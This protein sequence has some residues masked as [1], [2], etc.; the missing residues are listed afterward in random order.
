M[1]LNRGVL[2]VIK[3]PNERSKKKNKKIDVDLS[4]ECCFC[5]R[6]TFFKS[7]GGKKNQ[8]FKFSCLYINIYIPTLYA[9]S[10]MSHIKIKRKEIHKILVILRLFTNLCRLI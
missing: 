4:K 6:Q 7:V 8:L 1:R 3:P 9:F 10:Q 5:P 2:W